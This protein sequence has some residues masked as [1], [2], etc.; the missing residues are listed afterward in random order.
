MLTPNVTPVILTYNEAP[1]IGRSLKRLTW[2]KEVVV[3]D[4]FSTDETVQIVQSFPNVRLIQR[5][6]DGHTS[7][8]NFGLDA[9]HTDWVLTLDAD[10]ILSDDLIKEL[11]AWSPSPQIDAYFAKFRYCI[12]GKPLRRTL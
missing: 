5:R 8:W 10:Y 3:V 6:C 11:H 12:A 7:Q 4:S 9:V 2:A 1:N